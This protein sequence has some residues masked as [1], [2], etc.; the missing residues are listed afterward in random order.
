MS[1]AEVSKSM[2][3]LAAAITKKNMELDRLKSEYE[4]KLRLVEAYLSHLPMAKTSSEKDAG[5]FV[6]SLESLHSP[7][8]C[9]RC[10]STLFDLDK[11]SDF[12]LIPKSRLRSMEKKSGGYIR[13]RQTWVSG[14]GETRKDIPGKSVDSVNPVNAPNSSKSPRI[15]QPNTHSSHSKSKRTCSYCN[16]SG[17]S[18]ARC[19]TR[20][21]RDPASG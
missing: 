7:I 5:D 8:T 17:H 9:P 4:K 18:R 19:F 16:K 6:H 12:V 3:D 10:S 15:Y 2:G 11:E 14:E 21:S 20:L 13:G 1:F